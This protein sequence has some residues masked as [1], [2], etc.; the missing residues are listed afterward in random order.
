MAEN[1][2]I[3]WARHTANLW[4]GC[5]EVH[6]GCD[7]CY[8]RVLDNV[9]GG[10][11]PHWG[12][13][14]HRLYIKQVWKDLPKFQKMAA[15]AGIM[16][17]VFVNSM[18]D[19]FEKPH[20]VV[21]REGAGVMYG[22]VSEGGKVSPASTDLLRQR[23]FNE[24]DAGLYPNLLMLL[25]TKRPGN[26]PKY[27]P[28]SWREGAPQNVMYGTSIVDNKTKDEMLP[29][30]LDAAG[31]RFL[32]LEPLLGPVEF[33][34][35]SKRIDYLRALGKPA[36]AGIEWV[37]VGGESGFG[38]RPMHPDWVRS[39]RNQCAECG[40]A[41]HFKQWGE[42][43]P[44]CQATEEQKELYRK[45]RIQFPSPHNP[46]KI[47]TYYKLGKS[48]SGH[49]LDGVAYRAVPETSILQAA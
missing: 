26:I 2:E 47:N 25:L 42:Y 22:P 33:S 3:S 5:Q 39:L 14:S 44:E 10:G 38:A 41:F 49:L 7:N 45:R 43:L 6:A 46:S 1:T 34:D 21:D 11:T 36:L 8:A 27:I 16:E 15:A 40:V 48:L 29:R 31:R 37:I 24:I 13:D 4:W 19:I 9:R 20:W 17:A 12:K 18:S 35:A 30:L 23:L 32:S 28:E